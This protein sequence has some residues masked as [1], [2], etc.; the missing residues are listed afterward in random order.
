MVMMVMMVMMTVAQA[1][2]GADHTVC[3]TR[4]PVPPPWHQYPGRNSEL[5][6]ISLRF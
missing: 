3:V 5:T 6:E 4:L 2:C 1:S